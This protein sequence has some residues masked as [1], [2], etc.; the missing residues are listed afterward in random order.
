MA[1]STAG[2]PTGSQPRCKANPTRSRF[3][4]TVSPSSVVAASVESMRVRF[5]RVKRPSYCLVQLCSSKIH[6]WVRLK[7]RGWNEVRIDHQP[8]ALR[9]HTSKYFGGGRHDEVAA[10]NYIRR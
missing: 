6:V 9:I 3:A 8:R 10:E 4:A 7:G 1:R 2:A 5:A